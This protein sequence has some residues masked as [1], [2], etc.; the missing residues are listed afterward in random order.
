MLSAMVE[1]VELVGV[2]I[3]AASHIADEGIVGPAVP[4]ALD[5]IDELAGPIVPVCVLG[6][7]LKPKFSAA[8]G[9][10][11]V[12]TFQP[13]GPRSGDRGLRSAA[14]CETAPRRSWTRSRS[15]RCGL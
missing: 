12:T 9:F 11:V 1:H 14:R 2:E 10:D 4:Q 5:D 7:L 15:A 13:R 8:S 6:M 3:D